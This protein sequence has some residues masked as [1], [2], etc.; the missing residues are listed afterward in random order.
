MFDPKKIPIAQGNRETSDAS[1]DVPTA[2]RRDFLK[3]MAV[4]A[5][6]MALG[7]LTSRQAD[8]VDID[9][10][11]MKQALRGEKVVGGR[12][13]HDYR[14]CVGCRVCELACAIYN[15]QEVNPF[16][17]HIKIYTYQPTVFVGVVCQQCGDRPCIEACPVEPDQDGRRALYED[18]ETKALAVDGDR[19]IHCGSCVEACGTHRNGNLRM[20]EEGQPDGYCTLCGGD[21]QCVRKCPQDA[22]SVVPRTTDGRYAAK[23]ADYLA[24]EYIETLYGGPRTVIDALR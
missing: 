5:G 14:K 2:S 18:P 15:H 10:F 22:L 13:S 24:E 8:A 23:K 6:T 21:P 17:S 1:K 20:N 12:I 11:P 7:S 16:K 4:G 3:G 19:C 9:T